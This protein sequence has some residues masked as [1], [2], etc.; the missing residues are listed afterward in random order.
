MSEPLVS[1][2]IPVYNGENYL[3]QAIDSVINQTYEN[4]E[5][6]VVNDGSTDH[7]ATEKIALSYGSK[8]RY[9]QKENGGVATALNYGINQMAGD[10]FAWLSHDDIFYPEKI[11]KQMQ[12]L[13]DTDCRI[14]ACAYDIF[15][16]NGRKVPVP[17]V[18]FYGKEWI[19]KSVFSVIQSL[20]Q[21]G[22][23]LFSKEI[24][25]EYGYFRE[26]L[27]TTQDYE[28]LFRILRKEKCVYSNECLYGIR[29]HDNQG[30]KTIESVNT[31]RENMYKMFLEE[32]NTQ[33]KCHL[34]G[35]EYNF[36]YQ[37]LLRIWP[38]PNMEAEKKICLDNLKTWS[39]EAGFISTTHE[40][41]YIYGAGMYGKRLLF[42][43]RNREISAIGF[44]DENSSLWGQC[45]HG[46]PCYPIKK[47]QD[48]KHD[49]KVVVA[50]VFRNEIMK[51]LK[52]QGISKICF[53]EDYDRKYM[54]VSP[55][56]QKI[57]HT[58]M[59]YEMNNWSI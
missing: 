24:F 33:E 7:G 43:L 50:S 8:I 55:H 11:K 54:C 58:I 9:F 42:D 5:I 48:K 17:F 59:K 36:Y 52:N 10:Y 14:T 21:F 18:D 44:V 2:I 32:L 26:D 29:Y 31:D 28:F 22:G 53:K 30:S 57:N 35:S 49:Q 51:I 27:K 40:E 23:V 41:V 25:N 38:M 12:L 19:A 13:L 39:M 46:I 37:M 6:I 15:W 45:I 20:I 16:D 34:Y 3:Q 4:I 1:V 47:L 56:L